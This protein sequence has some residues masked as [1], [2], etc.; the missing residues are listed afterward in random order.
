[1]AIYHA[2][3]TG[4]AAS[5]NN[6]YGV[7]WRNVEFDREVAYQ[8]PVANDGKKNE[9]G[10]PVPFRTA[11][12]ALR[13]PFLDMDD[14]PAQQGQA[15]RESLAFQVPLTARFL[16]NNGK[17]ASESYSL[18]QIKHNRL[19]THPAILTVAKLGS[20]GSDAERDQQLILRVYNPAENSKKPEPLTIQLQ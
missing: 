18:A 7:L 15:L 14:A 20:R 5:G 2:G 4:W 17:N 16:P 13:L 9:F 8:Y 12:Y 1:I 6:L 10:K 3:V 19:S 11:E